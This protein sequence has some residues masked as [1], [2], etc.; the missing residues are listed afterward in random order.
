MGKEAAVSL[1]HHYI[2]LQA[3]G[4]NF[5]VRAFKPITQRQ[6]LQSCA[7]LHSGAGVL[8]SVSQWFWG[9]LHA[10]KGNLGGLCLWSRSGGT[11][12]N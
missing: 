6:W 12:P 11:F 2:G 5:V 3:M 4:G 7:V 8:P 1:A 9:Q 10:P